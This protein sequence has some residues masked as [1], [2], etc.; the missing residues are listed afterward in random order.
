MGN[1]EKCDFGVNHCVPRSRNGHLGWK[2]N[3]H[4]KYVVKPNYQQ[5][6]PVSGCL[7]ISRSCVQTF[8]PGNIKALFGCAARC[9][10]VDRY[11]G[12][13]GW[14]LDQWVRL[15][16]RPGEWEGESVIWS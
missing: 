4:D 8:F 13:G 10:I 14:L 11:A 12:G 5:H 7:P 9:V 6:D 15:V 3:S 16:A 1:W 2:L